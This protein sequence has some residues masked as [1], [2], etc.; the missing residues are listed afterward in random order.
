M[1]CRHLRAREH[2]RDCVQMCAGTHAH[3]YVYKGL[4]EV[5]GM[6]DG[7]ILGPHFC[8]AESVP[9]LP[10][11]VL[12]FGFWFCLKRNTV[13]RQNHVQEQLV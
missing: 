11:H 8:F 9:L 2:A 5:K 10:V 12:D 13:S 4:R 7:Q 3:M 1:G 6:A